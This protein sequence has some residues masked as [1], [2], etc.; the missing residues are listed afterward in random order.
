MDS[1]SFF[2][3]FLHSDEVARGVPVHARASLGIDP[4][5]CRQGLSGVR[6]RRRARLHLGASGGPGAVHGPGPAGAVERT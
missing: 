3:P 2:V 1:S 5:S 6:R 4:W